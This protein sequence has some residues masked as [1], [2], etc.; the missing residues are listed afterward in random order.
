MSNMKF[1]YVRNDWKK[2]DVT[3]VSDLFTEGDKTFVK[4]GWAFRC[5]HDK[6]I[7]REGRRLAI[8]R[9]NTSDPN[10]SASFEITPSDVKFFKI[11]AEIL[12]IIL[13]KETT[14]KKFFSDLGEDLQYFIHCANGSRPNIGWKEIFE[15]AERSV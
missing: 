6:F 7:K 8:E 15:K 9:M 4:C 3:I 10:Y 11:G 14:P 2:R 13:Q 5:N 1:M 12:S